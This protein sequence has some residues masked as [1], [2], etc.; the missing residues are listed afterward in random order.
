MG[1]DAGGG[2]EAPESPLAQ[3]HSGAMRGSATTSVPSS[4]SE[5]AAATAAAADDESR[6]HSGGQ[7]A[8]DFHMRHGSNAAAGSGLGEDDASDGESIYPDSDGSGG[9][10]AFGPRTDAANGLP[11][12]GQ[13]AQT[14]LQQALARISQLEDQNV[15]LWQASQLLGFQ[16]LRVVHQL[17]TASIL[18]AA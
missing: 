8:A 6:G 18:S 16:H 1:S 2:V 7:A 11:A 14:E 15:A 17:H 4:P 12:E 9:D 3:Q 10:E 5:D 13:D